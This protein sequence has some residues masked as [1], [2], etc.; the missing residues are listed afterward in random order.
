[1]HSEMSRGH[2][3]PP[4]DPQLRAPGPRCHA[5]VTGSVNAHWTP[6][7]GIKGSFS[8]SSFSSGRSSRARPA[9]PEK[10][11]CRSAFWIFACLAPSSQPRSA[12]RREGE[13]ER[14]GARKR[15]P[16]SPSSP[17]DR[18]FAASVPPGPG[19]SH[20]GRRTCWVSADP[21]GADAGELGAALLRAR[22]PL[23]PCSFSQNC[24]R[25]TPAVLPTRV[26]RALRP[27]GAAA[28]RWAPALGDPAPSPQESE[29]LSLGLDCHLIFAAV[30]FAYGTRRDRIQLG[31]LRGSGPFSPRR[32]AAREGGRDAAGRGDRQVTAPRSGETITTEA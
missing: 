8:G 9:P 3:A 1:M 29:A 17:A 2:T 16:K 10:R 30:T 20:P 31:R 14:C 23:A 32:F 18:P 12:G 11:R 21:R 27:P 6:L 22:Q 7:P 28:R 25:A 19:R 15:G 24:S 26:S 5:P 13:G 4:W